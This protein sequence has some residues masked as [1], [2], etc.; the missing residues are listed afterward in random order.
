MVLTVWEYAHMMA[1]SILNTMA[2]HLWQYLKYW[3]N[4]VNFTSTRITFEILWYYGIIGCSPDIILNSN[5]VIFCTTNTRTVLLKA[6][7][8]W[9]KLIW[10]TLSQNFNNNTWK[11][12][13]NM[14]Y[15]S[16][17]LLG[18]FNTFWIEIQSCI[19]GWI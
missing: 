14:R 15:N 18:Y 2:P 7:R 1:P 19:A 4:K 17:S 8:Y 10:L 16:L 5:L 12:E 11:G 6:E 3:W 9:E 13:L